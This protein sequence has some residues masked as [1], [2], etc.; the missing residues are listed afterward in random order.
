MLKSC[1]VLKFGCVWI[2]L[3]ASPLYL[4]FTV[5]DDTLKKFALTYLL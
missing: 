5:E 4:L 2:D 1:S 3:P